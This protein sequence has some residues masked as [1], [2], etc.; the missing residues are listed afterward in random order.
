[1]KNTRRILASQTPRFALI[2]VADIFHAPSPP[3][4]LNRAEAPSLTIA[5]PAVLAAGKNA[6]HLNVD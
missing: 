1:V 3:W 2:L 5:I 4:S 6:R